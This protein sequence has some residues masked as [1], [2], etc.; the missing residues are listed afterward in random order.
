[1]TPKN[2][3]IP[4]QVLLKRLH[5]QPKTPK[6]KNIYLRSFWSEKNTKAKEII[7]KAPTQG[8]Y[9]TKTTNSLSGLI[10]SKYKTGYLSHRRSKPTNWILEKT[11]HVPHRAYSLALVS[12]QELAME[13]QRNF[14]ILAGVF[15]VFLSC[16]NVSNGV[17]NGKCILLLKWA[18]EIHIWWL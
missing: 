12:V 6:L 2:V 13:Y 7:E 9:G 14:K 11:C 10:C 4:I 15:I 1:M 17:Y 16:T 18:D 8:F 5:D 3:K